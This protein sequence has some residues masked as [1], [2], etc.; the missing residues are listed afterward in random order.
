MFSN[1]SYAKI[2]EVDRKEKYTDCK[3]TISKKNPQGKYETDFSSKVRFLG[4]AHGF[5]PQPE[6]RIKILSCGTTNKFDKEKR[7]LYTNHF[8]FDYELEGNERATATPSFADLDDE[9]PF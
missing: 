7:V 5:N 9:C 8:I 1:G 3:I 2:W 6:Q 4:K